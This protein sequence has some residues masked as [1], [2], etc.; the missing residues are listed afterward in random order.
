MLIILAMHPPALTPT[1]GRPRASAWVVLRSRE[2]W[3]A[4]AMLLPAVL[5]LLLFYA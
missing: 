4:W 1:A 5:G 2:T 3:T